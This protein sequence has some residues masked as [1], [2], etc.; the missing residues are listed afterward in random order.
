MAKKVD[1][2]LLSQ[3]N[4]SA[5]G[6]EIKKGSS[7]ST[8]PNF[9]VF[10]TPINEDILVYIPKTN[11]IVTPDGEDMNLL[12]TY[13]HSYKEG[14]LYGQRRCINGLSGG[15]FN[16]LNYDGVCPA[17]EATKDEWALYNNKLAAEAQKIGIDPQNDPG[18]VL[19]TA[20]QRILGEMAMKKSEEY[21]TFPIVIIPTQG[22]MQPTPDAMDN[23]EVVYVTWRKKRYEDN[24]SSSL[25]A[26]MSNPG[27]PAGM[28]WVWKFSYTTDAQKANARDSAKNAK[29][30]PITEAKAINFLSQYAP[31]AEE[32]AREFTNDKATE[33]L[34]ANQYLYKEDLEAEVDKI[35]KKTRSLLELSE[36]SNV[37]AQPQVPGTN[38]LASFGGGD[39]PQAENSNLG[40]GEAPTQ[41]TGN[42]GGFSFEG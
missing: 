19:K 32:A 7:K 15:V 17:C 35:M 34:L 4:E 36:A 21:V 28:F 31:K 3:L 1:L 11:L 8:D 30:V 5:K 16:E 23:L 29:Y 33:V 6:Q 25:D 24:I 2:K 22:K 41:P 37:L 20:R 14:Q 42:T 39:A 18:D 40:V 27:H 38:P 13:V 9:P 26:L 10:R 12:E